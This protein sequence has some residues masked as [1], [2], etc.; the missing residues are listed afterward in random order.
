[1][2]KYEN[3]SKNE[4]SGMITMSKNVTELN[5]LAMSNK[6]TWKILLVQFQQTFRLL[7]L[8][9]AKNYEK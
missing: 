8:R 9:K 3:K 2:K 1:M 7:N 4:K 5:I 6:N